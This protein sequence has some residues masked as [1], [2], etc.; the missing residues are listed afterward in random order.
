[1]CPEE[2]ASYGSCSSSGARSAGG[3]GRIKQEAVLVVEYELALSSLPLA[4]C[5]VLTLTKQIIIRDDKNLK[6]KE[7]SSTSTMSSLKTIRER[8]RHQ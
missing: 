1:M 3:S 4:N 8:H 5:S 7:S 2:P 6:A